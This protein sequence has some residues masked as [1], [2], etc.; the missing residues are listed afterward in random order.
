M[1]AQPRT[2]LPYQDASLPVEARVRDLLGRMTLAEKVRQMSMADAG[3]FVAD[4]EVSTSALRDTF[5]DMGIG[6]LQDPRMDAATSAATV[7]AVQRYLVEKTRLGIPS[8]V[9]AECLHGHMSGGTT[10]FPQAIGLASTWNPELIRRMAAAV[11]RE[12]RAIGA[13]QALAPDLD[14]ARDPRWGRVEETYGEDPYLVEQMGVAYIRGMQG[15]G[16][17]VDGEHL[18]CT[19]K[20]FAAHGTPEAGM[21]LAPVAGGLHDLY[22][23]YLPPFEAAIRR[24]GALSIMPCYSEYE[25]VPAH[26]SKLLLTRVLR[27][28]WGFQGY[29]FADYGA[30]SMLQS[31]HRTAHDAAEAGRQALEAGLDLEAPGDYGYGQCLLEMVHRGE[32][33]EALVDQAVTRVLRVKFLAGLFEN[34]YA[35]PE[36]VAKIVHCAAHRRLARE[37]AQ[38]SIVLLRNEGGLLPLDPRTLKRIAVIGPNAD[39]AQ[40]GDYTLTSAAG[41][42]PLEGIRAAVGK[43]AE[44]VYAQG[45]PLWERSAEGFAEAVAAAEGSDVAVLVIGGASMALAG[46][47]WGS[48]SEV[49]TCGEGFDRTELS[50]PGL[51]EELV[52]AVHATGTPTVVVMV[53]GR[54]Y[55]I[56]WMAENIPAILD[57][58]YP[59]E[60][61]GHALADVLFGKVSPSGKLPVT[62]PRSV[63]HV[64]AFY[65]HRP[66]AR[67]YY[68]R[69]GSPEAAGRDYVFAPPSPLYGFGFGLSYTSFEYSDLRV[70][71]EEILPAGQVGVCVTVRNAGDRAGKEVVQVYLDDVVSSVTTPVRVLRG[72]RKVALQPGESA[73]VAFVLGPDDL[74]LMD[75]DGKWVVEPG[76]FRV[77]V[78]DLTAAFRVVRP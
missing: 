48:S 7:N 36:A 8:L 39:S 57:A 78:G 27:E 12:A 1:P 70:T 54:P 63:G 66:S 38:E 60:E 62:V 18:V 17:L 2:K 23:L 9:I 29:V 51:Q 28:Q 41:V 26:A 13:A 34:P 50:P 3:E 31:L 19:P 61:G 76:E 14:L 75:A 22:T 44:V 6:C 53:H 15:E 10:V 46:T 49:A 68:K 58:W 35:E 33:A 45:C 52:K 32:V 5:G 67:G 4:G 20:H 37:V 56:P 64:P 30:V 77:M 69:P 65:N 73:E 59:G 11:A 24:A 55:G 71:P 47:G 16:P 43:R 25:G 74:K 21:N 72:F 42:T 40:M